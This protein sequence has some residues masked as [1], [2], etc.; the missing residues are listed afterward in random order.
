MLVVCSLFQS[1][2]F[3]LCHKG[4]SLTDGQACCDVMQLYHFMLSITLYEIIWTFFV[5]WLN[6]TLQKHYF[7]PDPSLDT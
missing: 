5:D 2:L 6:I 4:V 3:A 1:G 7:R